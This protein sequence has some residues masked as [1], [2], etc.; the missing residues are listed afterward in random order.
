LFLFVVAECLQILRSHQEWWIIVIPP[1]RRE[2]KRCWMQE[3]VRG[4]GMTVEPLSE[5]PSPVG[6]M[7]EASFLTAMAGVGRVVPSGG[8]V[9]P[10]GGM[11]I[12][13]QKADES[14]L[15][16]E[17]A[18]GESPMAVS[19]RPEMSPI[20][21]VPVVASREPMVFRERARSREVCPVTTP[22]SRM[23]RISRQVEM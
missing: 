12:P 6:R 22:Q 3:R 13:Q 15:V 9:V 23:A 16:R 11:V 4:R 8:V 18:A 1:I 14:R 10:P 20:Q 2:E 19:K 5:Y 21:E 17:E 7:A